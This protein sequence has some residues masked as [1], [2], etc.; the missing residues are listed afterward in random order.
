MRK[1]QEITVET[2]EEAYEAVAN[3]FYEVGAAGV[4]IEDQE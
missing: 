2:T 4:V 3:L 1:W